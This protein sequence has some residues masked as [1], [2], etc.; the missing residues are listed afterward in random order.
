MVRTSGWLVAVVALGLG[1]TACK[2]NDD[3]GAATADKTTDKAQTGDKPAVAAGPSVGGAIGDDLSLLPADSEAVV[4][5]NFGQVQ[6]SALWKQFVAPKLATADLAGI[7]KFKALCGFDPLESLQSVSMGLKGLGGDS[8]VGAIVVHGFDKSKSMTCFDKEGVKDVEKDGSK[9]TI[10]GDVV[11]ITDKSGK[12][13][14][15]TFVNE[16]TALA[17][18]G[19]EAESKD[20]I[21]K[22]AAGGGSL[23]TSPAFVELYQKINSTESLWMVINGNAPMMQKAQIPGAKLK[24]VYGSL[25]VTDGLT[26][27]VRMRLGSPDE[28][29]QLVTMAKGQI[30]NPQAKQ[31]FDKIDVTSEGA[32]MK[33]SIAMSA[34]KLKQ[35]AA[36]VGGMMGGMMGGAGGGAGGGMGGP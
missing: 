5:I 29:T 20:G 10:D 34:E 2:K 33:I 23:K 27:D 18:I 21:K 36:M 4:G 22:V 19:P 13:I 1:I 16:T 7:Q 15:F 9:V 12:K 14:G 24:A 30:N 25:N 31:F 32:D 8:P 28:A 26:C 35:L 3:K 6:K 17:V 11:M